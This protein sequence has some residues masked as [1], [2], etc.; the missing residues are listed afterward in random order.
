MYVTVS[1]AA[2]QAP[3]ADTDRQHAPYRES[4]RAIDGYSLVKERFRES[5]HP[6][7]AAGKANIPAAVKIYVNL[8]AT[9]VSFLDLKPPETGFER[10]GDAVT[11]P[12]AM[13]VDVK[14]RSC[15]AFGTV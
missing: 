2:A 4:T 9:F 15:S 10:L 14:R 12:R 3:K 1:R 8:A 6:R 5:L 13:T 7:L 11:E